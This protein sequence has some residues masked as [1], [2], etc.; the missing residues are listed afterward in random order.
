MHLDEHSLS[1]K[2]DRHGWLHCAYCMQKWSSPDSLVSH[3][4][5]SH[6]S[7]QYQCPHCFNRQ[8]TR[9]GL[10]LHQQNVHGDKPKQEI[11][12]KSLP[13]SQLSMSLPTRV[14]FKPYKCRQ[15]NCAF[16]GSSA[17][18]LSN[19]LYVEHKHVSS[20]TD[21]QCMNCHRMFASSTS[22][23]LHSKAR[24]S[25]KPVMVNVRHVKTREDLKFDEDKEML[26]SDEDDTNPVDDP[27][28]SATN[29][30]EG[31][32]HEDQVVLNESPTSSSNE[33]SDDFK[34]SDK[35]FAGIGL[36]RCGNQNCNFKAGNVISFKLHISSCSLSRPG[37]Y[38]TCFHCRKQLKHVPTLLDHL[39]SHGL[40]RYLCSLCTSFRSALPI[41]VKSHMRNEHK[42][43][44][45]LKLCSLN[46]NPSNPEDEMYLVIPK[47]S[48]SRGNIVAKG[49]KLKDTFSPDE[50]DSIPP[51][52]MT[53]TVLRCSGKLYVY[54]FSIFTPI[55]NDLEV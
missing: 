35:G 37:N 9:M 3:V 36:Y 23:I 49:T 8:K 40:K 1:K 47:N 48:L 15:S 42:A 4:I 2:R 30:T 22:L 29:I 16:D 28:L 33:A 18:S 11:S 27:L 19:H 50:I 26:S 17:N 41:N 20:S 32:L 55:L 51:G 24:H 38:L 10:I 14:S 5:K 6:G 21:Y 34:K 46:T 7:C 13:I 12:C 45:N 43:T 54:K 31:K 52:S 53:R 25:M 39:K 44:N